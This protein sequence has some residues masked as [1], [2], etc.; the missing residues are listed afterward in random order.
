M[1]VWIM[2]AAKPEN[3]LKPR[4]RRELSQGNEKEQISYHVLVVHTDSHGTEHVLDFDARN[5]TPLSKKEWLLSIATSSPPKI[6]QSLRK[7]RVVEVPAERFFKN[8]FLPVPDDQMDEVKSFFVNEI[9]SR[10]NR[11]AQRFRNG[12]ITAHAY[13]ELTSYLNQ[14]LLQAQAKAIFQDAMY[15]LSPRGRAAFPSRTLDEEWEAVQVD[16]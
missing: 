16:E 3:A 12:E 1:K 4:L 9:V 8:H 2:T 14:Q 10:R 13:R 11:M 5:S 15:Y 6:S 7:I